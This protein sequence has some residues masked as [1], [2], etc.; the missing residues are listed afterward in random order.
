VTIGLRSLSDLLAC[1]AKDFDEVIVL[2]PMDLLQRPLN[3]AAWATGL[4][5][6]E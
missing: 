2:D 1:A 4:E 5:P 6:A 3:D